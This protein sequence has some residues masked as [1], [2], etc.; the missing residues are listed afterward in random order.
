MGQQL[1]CFTPEAMRAL[2]EYPWP[3]NVRELENA[4]EYA[5]AIGME[6]TLGTD[7]LPI[8]IANHI[9]SDVQDFRSVLQAYMNDTVPLAEIEKRYILSVLQ[10]FGGNQVRA[11]AAL[12]IDRSKLYRRLRTY[13]VKAVKFLQEEEQDGLQFRGTK[14]HVV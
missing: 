2:R 4:I 7:D 1:R 12:G 10:Q 5:L 13:G 14:A 8:E 3:G 6:E 9:T 11:A